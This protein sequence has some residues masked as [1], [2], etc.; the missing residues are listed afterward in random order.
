M[1]KRAALQE[2]VLT[3]GKEKL[4]LAVLKRLHN[5]FKEL[6]SMYDELPEDAV[7][8]G[9]I[10]EMYENVMVKEVQYFDLL[11]D[12]SMREADRAKQQQHEQQ[13][14]LQSLSLSN[15]QTGLPGNE[16]AHV[17]FLRERDLVDRLPKFEAGVL[18]YA[19]WRHRFIK[20]LTDFKI[21]NPILIKAWM[22]H[23]ILPRPE[24]E[25]RD[26][27]DREDDYENWLKILDQKFHSLELIKTKGEAIVHKL[28]ERRD[29]AKQQVACINMIVIC[30]TC[31]S[32]SKLETI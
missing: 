15:Q 3:N 28:K 19:A 25:V 24:R 32:Y 31:Q 16:S 21:N 22:Q 23:E 8:D 1:A 5:T 12:T 7:R 17:E 29:V 9:N 26:L 30:T 20:A 10:H 13:V 18:D 2:Q 14:Q 27:I 11:D 4:S 6:L